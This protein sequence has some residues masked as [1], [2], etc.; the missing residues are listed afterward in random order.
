MRVLYGANVQEGTTLDLYY[1][2]GAIGDDS[3]LTTTSFTAASVDADPGKSI[4]ENQ[5][6]EYE[7][8]IGATAA[9]TLPEFNAFQVKIVMNS[10]KQNIVPKIR[11]LSVIAL[12]T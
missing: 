6:K 1:R 8:N 5:Y 7:Y 9:T 10:T 4:D 2:T 11:D 3:D 12:G